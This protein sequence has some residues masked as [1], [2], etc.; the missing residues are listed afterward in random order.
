MGMVLNVWAI[1]ISLLV[2]WLS[3]NIRYA[4]RDIQENVA[5]IKTILEHEL[6]EDTGQLKKEISD[7]KGSIKAIRA[8][9][10]ESLEILERVEGEFNEIK[11]ILGAIRTWKTDIVEMK[12]I[13]EKELT[14]DIKDLK[15][16]VT[17]FSGAVLDQLT[18]GKEQ[19]ALMKFPDLVT[20]GCNVVDWGFKNTYFNSLCD[21]A[22]TL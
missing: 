13:L 2:G 19:K 4:Q 3:Y 20:L 5:N 18:R 15:K 6:T 10:N 9:T 22:K 7:I 11:K 14:D 17:D 1:G 21:I 8:W 12:T 16:T